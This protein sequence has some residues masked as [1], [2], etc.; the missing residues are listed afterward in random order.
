MCLSTLLEL[1]SLSVEES[2][3]NSSVV[4]IPS[5]C[6]PS[7]FNSVDEYD[8]LNSNTLSDFNILEL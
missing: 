6:C 4:S 8:E 1:P 5:R 7:L 3:S 2:S